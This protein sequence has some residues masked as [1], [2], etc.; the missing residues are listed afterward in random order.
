MASESD[1]PQ[2]QQQQQPAESDGV[3]GKSGQ[4]FSN[5]NASE[6]YDPCQEFATRSLQCMKRNAFD[7]EMCGDYFQVDQMSAT[8]VPDFWSSWQF[9][10]PLAAVSTIF[11]MLL[12][13]FFYRAYRDCKKEW[14][15]NKK[16]SK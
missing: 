8:A 14:L 12:I 3:W 1:Q 13:E 16:L 9:A 5:K 7:R 6:Y 11:D 4:R 15:T 10:P 2:Q